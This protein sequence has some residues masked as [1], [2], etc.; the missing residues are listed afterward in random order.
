MGEQNDNPYPT[1]DELDDV[2]GHGLREVA[3][4]AGIGA[5][6]LGAGGVAM[7]ASAGHGPGPAPTMLKPPTIVSQTQD[8]ANQ[9]VTDTTHGIGGV[10]NQTLSDTEALA[11]HTLGQ[12]N[13]ITAPVVTTATNTVQNATG[14]A[15]Q[16][17]GDTTTLADHAISGATAIVNQT[18]RTALDTVS[19]TER[20]AFSTVDSAVK[21]ATQQVSS[22]ESTA[23]GVVSATE[24]KVGQG[25]TLDLSILGEQVSTGGNMLKPSGTVTVLDSTGKAL[26]SAKVVNGAAT[27]SFDAAGHSGSYTIHYAG[28]AP[29]ASIVW[30]SPTL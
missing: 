3:A 28:N 29:S 26:A 25:W 9:L 13:S 14:L 27:V 15:N 6:V 10:T 19:A 12:V 21:T 24:D 2:E 22:V 11:G 16:T 7:A 18:E 4:A 8:D 23:I 30:L 1:N 17:V 20:T 5:A